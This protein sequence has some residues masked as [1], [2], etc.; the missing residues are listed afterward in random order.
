MNE[1]HFMNINCIESDGRTIVFAA[2]ELSA[3]IW[4][5]MFPPNSAL[6]TDAC[7]AAPLSASCSAAQRDR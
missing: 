3:S 7:V 1:L 6:V 5:S 4:A 2:G